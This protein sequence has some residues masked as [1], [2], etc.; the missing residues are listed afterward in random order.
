MHFIWD[1]PE[2]PERYRE[3]LKAWASLHLDWDITLWGD[4]DL[5]WLE[6]RDLYD[7]AAQFAPSHAVWQLRS[8]IA[9]Y[10]ILNRHGGLYVDTDFTPLRNIEPAL[11]SHDAFAVAET[12]DWV[13]NG[14]LYVDRPNHPVTELILQDLRANVLSYRGR[15]VR[16]VSAVSGPR[17]MTPRWRAH[18]CFE[19][20]TRLFLP[21]SYKDAYRGRF[22]D[23]T[24]LPPDT[25]AIHE[26]GHIRSI[27][28]QV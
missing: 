14:L 12:P 2:M 13:A 28:G 15:P 20:E 17:F 1:G 6:H 23:P 19:A 26:W 11:G 16:G 21:L 24:S 3:N 7:D 10:E 18:G 8:D 4:E 22:V 9:R 5:Q 25:Y 27:R